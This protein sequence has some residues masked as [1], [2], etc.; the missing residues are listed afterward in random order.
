M[1]NETFNKSIT[2]FFSDASRLTNATG[3]I[4]KNL[5][6]GLNQL[7]LNNKVFFTREDVMKLMG[8][9]KS[10]VNDLFN[11]PHFPVCTLG[12]TQVVHRDALAA[13]FSRRISRENS[14][15]WRKS[16]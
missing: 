14:I 4:A 16:A 12:K 3:F 5:I 6:E 1:I 7:I 9:S 11:D 2:A 8:C 13:Y 15:Y 10:T